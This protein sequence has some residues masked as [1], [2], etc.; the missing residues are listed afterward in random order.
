[1]T[2]L[3]IRSHFG[4]VPKGFADAAA[5]GRLAMPWEWDV[6]PA[7]LSTA[8]GVITTM[9]LDQIRAETWRADLD[10]LLDRGGRIWINGHV[11]RP[12][13]TGLKPF[14]L[15]GRGRADLLQTVLADHPVFDGIDRAAF[16][17]RRGVAGFYG[18]GHNPMPEGAVALTGVGAARVP[19]DWEWHRPG[20][21]VVFSHAGNDIWGN[22]DDSAVTARLVAAVLA[23]TAGAKRAAVPNE[24]VR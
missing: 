5:A 4:G 10:A 16:Q 9:H 19:L 23:W 21:G 18:R 12:F 15:A 14:V 22:S 3:L 17:A 6:T 11:A 20:G 1:M 13:V 7:L 2:I 8:R 24:E